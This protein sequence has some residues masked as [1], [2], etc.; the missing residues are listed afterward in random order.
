MKEIP[1]IFYEC[2]I[3]NHEYSDEDSVKECEEKPI[4]QYKGVKVGDIVKILTGDGAGKFGKV[5]SIFIYSKDWGHYLAARYHHTVGLTAD[6]LDSWGSRQ[7][8]FDDYE[9]IK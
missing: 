1:K 6:V 2:E 8:T 5:T 9:L 3:C 7:L 4:S